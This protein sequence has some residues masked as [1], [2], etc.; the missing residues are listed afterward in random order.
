MFIENNIDIY[1]NSS[2]WCES[3]FNNEYNGIDFLL[4]MLIF[5]FKNFVKVY[6]AWLWPKLIHGLN[7]NRGSTRYG[8]TLI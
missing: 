1:H 7:K 2:I 6:K 5:L 3:T 8:G 4:S